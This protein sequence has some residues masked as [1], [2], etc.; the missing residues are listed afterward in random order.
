[1][2]SAGTRK[3]FLI[4]CLRLLFGDNLKVAAPTGVASLIIDRTIL[5]SLLHLPTKGEFK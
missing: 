1:M 2:G 4:Q 3:S 5:H